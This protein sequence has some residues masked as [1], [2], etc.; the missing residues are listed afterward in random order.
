MNSSLSRRSK[1]YFAT[2]HPTALTQKTGREN[3]LLNLL[4]GFSPTAQ[5]QAKP[6]LV[7]NSASL[8]PTYCG[9]KKNLK[10]KLRERYS[11]TKHGKSP[12]LHCTN[13]NLFAAV[14]KKFSAIFF[15]VTAEIS[16]SVSVAAI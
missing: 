12:R 15:R 14:N 13:D 7:G 16:R 8:Y 1:F 10:K 4:S 9:D 11:Q 2:N 5:F 6:H 3:Q